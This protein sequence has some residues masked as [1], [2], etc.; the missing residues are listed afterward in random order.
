MYFSPLY[1]AHHSVMGVCGICIGNMLYHYAVDISQL[2]W[3]RLFREDSIGDY[4]EALQIIFLWSL[5]LMMMTEV[6]FVCAD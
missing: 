3:N 6:T 1:I 4:I 2:V 5:L